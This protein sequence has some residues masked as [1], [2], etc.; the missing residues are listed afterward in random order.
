MASARELWKRVKPSDIPANA[1]ALELEEE[2]DPLTDAVPESGADSGRSG[3]QL[4]TKSRMALQLHTMRELE[5]LIAV[6]DALETWA[7]LYD[8]YL[9]YAKHL[10][11]SQF[12]ASTDFCYSNP[13]QRTKEVKK[14]M[15]EYIDKV[16]EAV[17]PV[18]GNFLTQPVDGKYQLFA[19]FRRKG[20]C[21]D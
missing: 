12:R 10:L 13:S 8:D 19:C 7:N 1:E 3:S 4:G 15:Q 18:C 2:E 17:E 21:V 20:K 5:Q 11:T 6:F 9:K 14:Q 16:T